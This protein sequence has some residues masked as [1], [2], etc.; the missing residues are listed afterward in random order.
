VYDTNSGLWYDIE[1]NVKEQF[2]TLD[3]TSNFE[4]DLKSIIE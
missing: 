2:V 4:I 1:T 3:E